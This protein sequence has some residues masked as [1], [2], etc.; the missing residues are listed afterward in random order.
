MSGILT[1]I[2]TQ[3]GSALGIS[4]ENAGLLLSCCILVSIG[5][6]LAMAGKKANLLTVAIPMIATMG[7]LVAIAWLPYWILF[8]LAMLVGTTLGLKFKEVV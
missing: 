4:A 6:I 7:F 5:L 1:D 3:V 8:V 2:P